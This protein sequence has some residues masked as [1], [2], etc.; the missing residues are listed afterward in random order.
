M[1]QEI[2]KPTAVIKIGGNSIA[3]AC[4]HIPL[5]CRRMQLVVLHGAGK[6][7]D[8]ALARK[9]VKIRKINGLRVTDKETLEIVKSEL[10]KANRRIVSGLGKSGINAKP[11]RR[12][13][14]AKKKSSELG[15]VGETVS[16]IVDEIKQ[17][18]MH[19]EVPVII[20]LGYGK[21][22]VYNINADVA[23]RMLALKLRPEKFILLNEEGGVKDREGKVIEELNASRIRSLVREGTVTEG[24]K[25]KLEEASALLAEADMKIIICAAKDLGAETGGTIIRR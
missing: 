25:L 2:T 1:Y 23:A 11:V 6:Q 21:G 8:A 12:V 17:C 16:V 3:E 10:E 14:K 9:G 7:I 15:Y 22:C 4:R 24:M 18:M 20:P 5:L 13:F 19:Q